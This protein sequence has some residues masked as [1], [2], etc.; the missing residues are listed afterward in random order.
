MENGYGATWTADMWTWA[1]A[2]DTRLEY[3]SHL[4]AREGCALHATTATYRQR[5][6][7]AQVVQP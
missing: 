7:P 4:S 6:K 1:E 3:N 2:D 5:N